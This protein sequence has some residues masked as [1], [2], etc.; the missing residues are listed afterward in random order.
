MLTFTQLREKLNVSQPQLTEWIRE[1]L[2]WEGTSRKKAFDPNQVRQWLL[3]N[4]KVREQQPPRGPIG[5]VCHTRSEAARELGVAERTIATWCSYPDFPGKPGHRGRRE[6]HYPIPEI[7]KWHART[8]GDVP[9]EGSANSARERKDNAHAAIA[10]LDLA[11]RTGE[12][13]PLA[14]VI[15]FYVRQMN[16]AKAHLAD[17]PDLVVDK[18]P[19]KVKREERQK[20]RDQVEEIRYQVLET[21]VELLKGDTDPTE[22]G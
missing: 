12:L 5:P 2:P 22:E 3:D 16:Q 13:I 14:D 9:M 1:G 6:G 8:F 19:P 18:L 7:R 15:G 21:F 11:E 20:I 10:E 4:G 17:L